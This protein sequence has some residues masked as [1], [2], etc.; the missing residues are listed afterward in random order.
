MS[1][2]LS[3]P[4]PTGELG[5]YGSNAGLYCVF[6]D[7]RPPPPD[8]LEPHCKPHWEQS[9]WIEWWKRCR[10]TYPATSSSA[11]AR[12]DAQEAEDEDSERTLRHVRLLWESS[13]VPLPAGNSRVTMDNV[14]AIAASE[15]FDLVAVATANGFLQ[16][17]SARKPPSLN[18]M[19]RMAGSSKNAVFSRG[20][21][22]ARWRKE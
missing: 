4:P 16:T 10:P 19:E 21:L 6:P 1:D 13:H 14:L 2:S 9:N 12:K 7:Q 22:A 5:L 17:A 8:L 20:T 15:S 11:I 18:T 3:P